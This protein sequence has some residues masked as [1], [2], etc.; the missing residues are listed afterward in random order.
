MKKG[1]LISLLVLVILASSCSSAQKENLVATKADMVKVNPNRTP[2]P[3]R[4]PIPTMTLDPTQEAM[5]AL[6]VQFPVTCDN[7]TYSTSLSPN[8]EWLATSC[9]TEIN[10]KM[11]VQNSSGESWELNILDYIGTFTPVGEF[12]IIPGQIVPASWSPDGKY[13]YFSTYFT[14]GCGGNV[15]F[16]YTLG[17]ALGLFRLDLETRDVVTLIDPEDSIQ[18]LVDFSPTG[19]YYS[20]S[21]AGI[22]II[23]TTTFAKTRISDTDTFSVAW[24]PDGRYL[25]YATALCG[26]DEI[27]AE[28]SALS[29][30]DTMTGEEIPVLSLDGKMLVVDE[31]TSNTHLTYTVITINYTEFSETTYDFNLAN[32]I[33]TILEVTKQ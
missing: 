22:T 19:E 24:S 30:Y 1:V 12:N 25:A 4:N 15:R 2:R 27:T 7:F 31:W 17:N 23:D 20:I 13:L 11:I 32:K 26:E 6:I 8:K 21:H 18:Y 3:Q 29:I 5:A 14:G 16:C 10:Q 9:E 33:H 28:E